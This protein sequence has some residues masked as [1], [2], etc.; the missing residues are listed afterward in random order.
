MLST[1]GAAP[2]SFLA[3]I[4]KE[5]QKVDEKK[6]TDS[7]F[8]IVSEN[9]TCPLWEKDTRPCRSGWTKACFFCKYA[10]FRT[11]ECIRRAT[12]LP[13]GTKLYSICIREENKE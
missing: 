1:W 5:A 8:L 11:E 4:A 3:T 6:Y 10:H 13:R 12:E 7:G 9:D 2:K